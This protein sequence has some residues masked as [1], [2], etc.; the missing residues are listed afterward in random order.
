[1]LHIQ[2]GPARV[3]DTGTVTAFMGFPLRFEVVHSQVRIAV[4]LVFVTDPER[5]GIDVASEYVGACLRLTC[6]NFDTPEG[7][8]SSRPVLLGEA[9]KDAVFLHFKVFRYGQTDDHT[10]HYTFF[11][12]DRDDIGLQPA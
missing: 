7:R 4:E 11:A 10:V 1:M 9:G 3:I 12:A 8:G 6:T 5:E 2:S